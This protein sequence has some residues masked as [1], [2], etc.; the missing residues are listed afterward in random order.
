VIGAHGSFGSIRLVWFCRSEDGRSQG[1]FK[2]EKQDLGKVNFIEVIDSF[3]S[4]YKMSRLTYLA[5]YSF[6]EKIGARQVGSF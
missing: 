5:I 1:H 4:L 6:E 3:V 2:M